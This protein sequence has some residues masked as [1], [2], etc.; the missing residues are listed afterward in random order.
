M[1]ISSE[2]IRTIIQDSI[3][4]VLENS[5]VDVEKVVI[6]DDLKLF[7]ESAIFDSIGF[8]NFIMTLE[9]NFKELGYDINLLDEK[10]FSIKNS[11]FGNVGKIDQYIKE[12]LLSYE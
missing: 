12:K 2:T 8:V 11:P 5:N 10:A 1:A 9:Q 3:L 4:E 6:N 7:S